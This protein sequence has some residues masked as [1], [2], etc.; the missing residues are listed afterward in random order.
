L[1]FPGRWYACV[2]IEDFKRQIDVFAM[3]GAVV[4]GEIVPPGDITGVRHSR[5]SALTFQYP[6]TDANGNS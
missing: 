5:R 2:Q 6:V 3:Y 4:P 1:G